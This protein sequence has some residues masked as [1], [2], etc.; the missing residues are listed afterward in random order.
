LNRIN[1]LIQQGI[2][3]RAFHTSSPQFLKPQTQYAYPPQQHAPEGQLA[4][5]SLSN[6]SKSSGNRVAAGITAIVLSSWLFMQFILGLSF[7]L[8]FL[9]FLSLVA[10]VGT[11]ASGI[12]LLAKQRGRLRGCL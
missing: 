2:D 4:Y 7:G 9:A 11:L 8:G 10:A 5:T 3:D 12:F 6:L 1:T